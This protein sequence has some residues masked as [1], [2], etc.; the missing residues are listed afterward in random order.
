MSNK[1]WV[2]DFPSFNPGIIFANHLQIS[3][4][5]IIIH[6]T[7][8]DI[9]SRPLSEVFLPKKG[10][11]ESEQLFR[12]SCQIHPPI[13]YFHEPDGISPM[14]I[15]PKVVIVVKSSRV[16]DFP[17]FGGEF[18]IHL[19]FRATEQETRISAKRSFLYEDDDRGCFQQWPWN[20]V[21]TPSF[22]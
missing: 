18:P 17:N 8:S 1:C 22:I 11:A 21:K 5:W 20:V 9:S 19:S 16:P 2:H 13:L 14:K 3:E 10:R 12:C 4:Y 7:S 6:A 15:F